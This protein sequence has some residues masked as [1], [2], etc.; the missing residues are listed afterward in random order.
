MLI[1]MEKGNYSYLLLNQ[2]QHIRPFSFEI[3]RRLNQFFMYFPTV[4]YLDDLKESYSILIKRVHVHINNTLENFN[5]IVC[6]LNK[7]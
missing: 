3:S 2:N 6:I 4:K 5:G 1:H 7:G